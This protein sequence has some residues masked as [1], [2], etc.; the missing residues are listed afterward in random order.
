MMKSKALTVLVGLLVVT[1]LSAL[2]LPGCDGGGGGFT[3]LTGLAKMTPQDTGTIF[4]IDVIKFKSDSDF[5][6]LYQEMKDLF[7]Y[8]IAAD[9]DADIMDFDDIHYIGMAEVNYG[10]VI[11]LNGDFNLDAIRDQLKDDDYDKDDYMG[12]EIWYGDNDAVAIHNSTLILGDEDGV[13]E[14]IEAITDPDTSVYEKNENMRDVISELSPGLFF[15]VTIE[16]F[17]PGASGVGMA[18]S[19]VNADLMEFSGCFLFDDNEDAEDALS[20]IEGDMESS[21][22]YRVDVSRSGNLVKFSAE[23]D[24]E[25]AGVFW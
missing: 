18:F 15:M 25:E 5:R 16:A 2:L 14:S 8:E 6:E 11:W 22:F 23:M 4:F 13:E 24:M 3:S 7:E 17:Y 20:D 12:V 21:D 10:E 1:L 9:S 19:K